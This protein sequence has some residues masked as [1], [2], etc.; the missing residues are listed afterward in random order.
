ME[1][2]RPADG[3][4]AAELADR[5]AARTAFWRHWGFEPWSHGALAGAARRQRFVKDG[6]LGRI[7]EYGAWDYIVW[8]PGTPE[9]REALW[10]GLRPRPDI[11]TQRF[12]MLRPGP[13]PGRRVKSFRLGF[14]GYAE[15]YEY[16]PGAGRSTGAPADLA[17][18]ADLA[19]RAPDDMENM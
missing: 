18:L 16:W 12:L 1:P 7:A 6:L 15:L 3:L 4:T 10:A 8:R 5:L 13:R 11:M 19:L 14:C 9:D 17:G 2:G